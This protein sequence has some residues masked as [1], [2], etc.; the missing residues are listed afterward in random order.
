MPEMRFQI[1]WPDGS[2]EICYSPSL[3]IKEYFQTEQD[4]PL[5]DF[6]TRSRTALTIAS[7]RVKAKFGYPC[8]LA[9]GQLASIEHKAAQ[10]DSMPNPNVRIL[11]FIE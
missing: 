9:L 1:Q 2:Q 3:V 7:E 8:S 5:S 10:Y 11:R 4:Y 6:V